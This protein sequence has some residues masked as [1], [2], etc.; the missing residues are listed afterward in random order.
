M[1]GVIHFWR[2]ITEPGLQVCFFEIKLRRQCAAENE[3][4][5]LLSFLNLQPEFFAMTNQPSQKSKGKDKKI[6]DLLSQLASKD[7]NQQILAVKAMKID[8][9]ET[10]IRPLVIVLNRTNSQELKKEIVDLLNTIKSTKVPGEIVR[11]LNNPD[12]SASHQVLLA[13]IWNSGLDYRDYMGDI[14]NATIQG[15]FMAAMECL[16]I[17]ENLESALNE[18]QIM[19]ALLVFKSYLVENR[20]EDESKNALIQEIVL[21]LQHMNDTV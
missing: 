10:V 5:S 13:S 2:M 4:A 19:D 7:E 1:T 14:A 8:G 17:L 3:C 11:C 21:L 16:T 20:K 6:K 15:D 12:F 9:N 18:D